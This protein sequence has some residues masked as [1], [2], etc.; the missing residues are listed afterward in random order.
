[1]TISEFIYIT[2]YIYL[3]DYFKQKERIYNKIKK[4]LC[5]TQETDNDNNTF[6]ILNSGHHKDNIQWK[7]ISQTTLPGMSNFRSSTWT[8]SET[9]LLVGNMDTM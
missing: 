1:M 6:V 2:F 9:F 5:I 4:T 7:P 3:Y 8:L